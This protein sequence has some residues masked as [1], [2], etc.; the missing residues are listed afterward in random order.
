VA[1]Y[2]LAEGQF[3]QTLRAAV[4]GRAMVAAALGVHPAVVELILARYDE[5]HS[6]Q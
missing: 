6:R 3:T 1:T 5:A 4:A 2:L